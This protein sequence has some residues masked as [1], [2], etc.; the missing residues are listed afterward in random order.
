MSNTP[1]ACSSGASFVQQLD[2]PRLI[3]IHQKSRASGQAARTALT[4]SRCCCAF[5]FIFSTGMPRTRAPPRAPWPSLVSMPRVRQVT[6]GPRGIVARARP[7]PRP[8]SSWPPDPTRHNRPHWRAPPAGSRRCSCERVKPGF[9]SRRELPPAPASW[10]RS[11]R[12]HSRHRRLPHDR[13]APRSSR[14]V[15]TS[16]SRASSTPREI[17][18]GVRYGHLSASTA[19]LIT[20]LSAANCGRQS[21]RDGSRSVEDRIDDR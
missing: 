15:T 3:G 4:A 13:G 6:S 18:N 21:F 20:P 2:G 16:T 9:Q 5:T 12:L 1:R 19:S 8:P 10:Y 14:S 7:R 17:R 11:S